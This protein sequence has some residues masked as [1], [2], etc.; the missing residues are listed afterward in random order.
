[1]SQEK[2]YAAKEVAF[3]VLKKCAEVYEAKVLSKE[4]KAVAEAM[5]KNEALDK[6]WDSMVHHLESKEGGGHSKKSAEKIAGYINNKYV[7]HYRKSEMDKS[8]EGTDQKVESANPDKVPRDGNEEQKSQ[9]LGEKLEAVVDQH[10]AEHGHK[11]VEEEHE[12]NM[13]GHLKLA[14]FMGRME[15][16]REGKKSEGTGEL[17]KKEHSAAEKAPF[18]DKINPSA[19]PQ[20]K[21]SARAKRN[22]R[23]IS[24]PEKEHKRYFKFQNKGGAVPGKKGDKVYGKP[25]DREKG[26]HLGSKGDG[27]LKGRSGAGINAEWAGKHKNPAHAEQARSKAK[28]LHSQKLQEMKNQ[29]KPNLPKSEKIKGDLKKSDEYPHEGTVTAKHGEF[30]AKRKDG[31]LHHIPNKEHGKALLGKPV[32]FGINEMDDAVLHPQH[33]EAK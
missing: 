2:K 4:E 24:T 25:D 10:L 18:K 7:H 9:S 21:A 30:F 27:D 29:P 23:G 5:M 12:E 17:E 31:G 6:N 28:E 14:K 33:S 13:K 16:K 1:M 11:E 3:A 26:V 32:K 22:A 15:Q 8:E 20:V 19:S